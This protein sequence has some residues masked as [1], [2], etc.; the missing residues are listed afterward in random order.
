MTKIR[1]GF[2]GKHQVWI[3][4]IVR[5]YLD[6]GEITYARVIFAWYPAWL[7]RLDGGV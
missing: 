4:A 3:F 6:D 5:E 7:R 2:R 1:I